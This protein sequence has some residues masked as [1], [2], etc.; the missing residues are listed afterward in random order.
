[1]AS[2]PIRLVDHHEVQ[3]E[4]VVGEAGLASVRYTALSY[5]WGDKYQALQQPL[6]TRDNI[7]DRL[8]GIPDSQLSSVLRD[9]VLATRLLSIRYLWVDSLCIL[10][11]DQRDW[12]QQS[13]KMEEIYR[14]AYVTIAT[15]ASVSC[16]QGFRHCTRGKLYLSLRSQ[17]SPINNG[18]FSLQ[19]ADGAFGH[20]DHWS[21]VDD[22]YA[23]VWKS[24]WASRG[25]TFQEWILSSRL[26]VFGPTDVVFD[27]D[28]STYFQCGY[29]KEPMGI[30]MSRVLSTNDWHYMM[31]NYSKRHRGF[32]RPSDVLP[33]FSGTAARFGREMR[34]SE[35][36]YAAG[37]WKQSLFIDLAWSMEGDGPLKRRGLVDLL[38]HLESPT[39]YS[40]PSWTCLGKGPVDFNV[41]AFDKSSLVSRCTTEAWTTLKG[42]NP[43]G[44]VKAGTVRLTGPVA[45]LESDLKPSKYVPPRSTKSWE[46]KN[47]DGHPWKFRLDWDPLADTIFPGQLRMVVTGAGKLYWTQHWGNFGILVHETGASGTFYRVGSFVFD[48]TDT[49]P[50]HP[51]EEFLARC[52][53]RT[54]D[55]I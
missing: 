7:Q 24:H 20:N 44:E 39:T 16:Q 11:G 42:D 33:A 46:L 1:M 54:I 22:H 32:S 53:T 25:W 5:C 38:G 48:P 13:T 47:K 49:R 28:E 10:Q 4:H 45:E 8:A 12:E 34:Y 51:E 29:D 23:N 31:C 52:E 41:D 6:T 17:L 27:C 36:D 14:S 40:L 35:H 30:R 15:P 18:I 19:H 3:R 9:A 50:Q 43:F 2:E 21:H 55:I 26:L 37:L